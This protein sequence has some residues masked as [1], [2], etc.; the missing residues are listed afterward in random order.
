MSGGVDSSTA[1]YLL[2]QQGYE[3]IGVHMKYWNEEDD[4]E[5]DQNGVVTH[6][7]GRAN[8]CCSLESV[9]DARLVANKIGIPFYVVDFKENFKKRIVDY[10]IE[11]FEM[12]N[13]PN[14]CVICNRDVKFGLLMDYAEQ[15]GVDYIATGHYARVEK[16]GDKF[17][18]KKALDPAKDQSYFLCLLSQNQLSK[19]ILP[20]GGMTKP[21]VRKI[22]EDAG[23]VTARKHDS[24][25]LCFI[26]DDYRN[27]LKKYMSEIKSGPIKFRDGKIIGEHNGLPFHTIGQRKGLETSMNIPLYVIGKDPQTNSLI[28]GEQSDL[29]ANEVTLKNFNLI[30]ISEIPSDQTA[31]ISFRYQGKPAILDK[32]ERVGDNDYR[33]RFTGMNQ[34]PTP[35]QF[36]VI[37]Q[38]ENCL[39]GGIIA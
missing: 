37:Y 6:M 13:T 1:A 38:N 11:Q 23:L 26:H 14:P 36:G 4:I 29:S 7:T 17:Q 24:Q 30:G 33:L 31:G 32:V 19:V 28:V 8:K 22:A 39:G 2:K 35:G 18:L 3:V 20:L 21:E 27:F 9:E 34:T 12:G 16:T 10:Y 25:D 5:I 15:V